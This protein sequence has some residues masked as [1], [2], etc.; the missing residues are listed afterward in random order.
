MDVAGQQQRTSESFAS[1]TAQH[2]SLI[3][4]WC[5]Y[6]LDPVLTM[7]FPAMS[8]VRIPETAAL[9]RSVTAA[10]QLRAVTPP[11]DDAVATYQQA[12]DKL[13]LALATAEVAARCGEGAS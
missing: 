10:A 1:V 2:D 8:D 9:I 11:T 13:A 4:Q 5:R 3:T 12:V 7:D 6:E